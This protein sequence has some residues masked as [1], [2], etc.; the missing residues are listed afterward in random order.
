[1]NTTATVDYGTLFIQGNVHI[2]ISQFKFDKRSK[3]ENKTK[4]KLAYFR[5]FAYPRLETN[6]EL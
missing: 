2:L 4:H 1:M 3:V 6:E 5:H